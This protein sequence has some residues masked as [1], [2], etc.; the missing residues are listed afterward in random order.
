MPSGLCGVIKIFT[1]VP[2]DFKKMKDPTGPILWTLHEK[3]V[4]THGAD[5]KLCGKGMLKM[6]DESLTASWDGPTK[7]LECREIEFSS[8]LEGMSDPIR[9]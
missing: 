7:S 8:A 3:T 4:T 2:Q 1:L 9:K 6:Q 5:D